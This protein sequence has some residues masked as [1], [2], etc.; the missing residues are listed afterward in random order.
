MDAND[1]GFLYGVAN[2]AGEVVGPTYAFLQGDVLFF[3]DQEFG[4]VA[5]ELEVFHHDS[6]NLTVVLVLPEAS[7]GRAFARGGT[8]T[9][10]ISRSRSSTSLGRALNFSFQ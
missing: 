10:L 2:L 4:V 9:L 1:D 6:G 8:V 3:G 5:A 7:V